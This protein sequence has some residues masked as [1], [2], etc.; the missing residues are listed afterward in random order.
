MDRVTV[1]DY[2]VCE[3]DGGEPVSLIRATPRLEEAVGVARQHKTVSV[4][5]LELTD[6]GLTFVGDQK[7]S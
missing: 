7:S 1:G 6:L 4:D 5:I 3:M 2:L